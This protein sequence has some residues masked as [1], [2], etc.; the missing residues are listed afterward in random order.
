LRLP[1]L[2]KRRQESMEPSSAEHLL[3]DVV[4]ICAKLKIGDLLKS[5]VDNFDDE[6][7]TS[8]KTCIGN[9]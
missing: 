9:G 2:S 6:D 4:N 8:R 5:V 1:K 7:A 3:K